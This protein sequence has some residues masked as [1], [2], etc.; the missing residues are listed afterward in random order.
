MV[1]IT[2]YPTDYLNVLSSVERDNINFYA[3]EIGYLKRLLEKQENE[4]LKQW[5]AYFIAYSEAELE[6]ANGR[7]EKTRRELTNRELRNTNG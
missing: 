6:N 5:F 7:L 4:Q 2:N 1:N 3:Q